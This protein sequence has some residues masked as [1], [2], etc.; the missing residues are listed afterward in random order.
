MLSESI[1]TSSKLLV[2][3]SSSRASFP[4][5]RAS[6]AISRVLFLD[7]LRSPSIILPIPPTV[8]DIVV[9]LSLSPPP[10]RAPANIALI[11]PDTNSSAFIFS[12][13]PSTINSAVN[14]STT[15]CNPSVIASVE[16]PAEVCLPILPRLLVNLFMK[17][18]LIS[19]VADFLTPLDTKKLAG[20]KASRLAAKAPPVNDPHCA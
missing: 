14:S 11:I 17:I 2:S 5:V 4:A 19:E 7:C 6:C 10:G 16:A 1:T 20:N 12:K 15:N 18:S 13:L 8:S 9:V 3:V